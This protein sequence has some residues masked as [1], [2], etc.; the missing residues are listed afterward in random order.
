MK[1][2]IYDSTLRDGTQQEGISLSVEDKLAI[3][4]KLDEIGVHYIEGG[5]AGANPKD[6][7]YFKKVQKLQL[8]NAKI[9]AFGNTRRA[10]NNSESDP[11]LKALIDTKAEILTI[12]GKSSDFQVEKVLQTSLEENMNMIADSVSYLKSKNRIVFFDAEHFFDGYKSNPEYSV[13]VLKIALN[14]GAERLILCDTNGGT[15]PSEIYKITKEVVNALPKNA[16]IGIH[17]HNDT[18]TAVASSLAAYEAGAIQIQG[19]VN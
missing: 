10:N 14:N 1:I 11:T 13:N 4:Q 3:T 16:V 7:E 6:D 15:L 5:F 8:K 12:V 19:C 17:T 18:D 2:E 9:A